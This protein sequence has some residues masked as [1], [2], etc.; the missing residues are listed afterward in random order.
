M[1]CLDSNFQD[2]WLSDS[3]WLVY[4]NDP[5]PSMTGNIDFLKGCKT[6]KKETLKIHS[7]NQKHKG[8]VVKGLMWRMIQQ[9]LGFPERGKYW[10]FNIK[11]GLQKRTLNLNWLNHWKNVCFLILLVFNFGYQFLL[12]WPLKY[13]L[14]H[15]IFGVGGQLTTKIKIPL[16]GLDKRTISPT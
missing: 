14:G 5:I 1:L 4:E 8:I 2:S 13:E 15:Q 11:T 6:F 16:W 9:N 7:E 3:A 10:T 12:L